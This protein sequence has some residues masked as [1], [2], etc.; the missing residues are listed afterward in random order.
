MLQVSGVMGQGSGVMGLWRMGSVDGFVYA[1][2]ADF[3][4]EI[5]SNPLSPLAIFA[6]EDSFKPALWGIV[7]PGG[8]IQEQKNATTLVFSL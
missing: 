7:V 3:Q 1:I 2:H 6:V 5:H 4:L 8:F